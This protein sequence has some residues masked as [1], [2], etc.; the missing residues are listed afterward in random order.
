MPREWPA[1]GETV[2]LLRRLIRFDTR[3]PPGNEQPAA[4]FMVELF[5][6]EGIEARTYEA[7]PGRLQ[8][9]ARLKGSSKKRPVMLLAHTD[10]VGVERE[11]WSC[12][13]FEG[14]VRDGCVYGRG[15]IDDKGM[16]AANAMALLLLNRKIKAGQ[17]ALTR[18]VVF[19]ATADEEAGGEWGMGWL[20][21]IH[22][23][24]LDAEFALNEGGRTR[25]IAGGRRYLAIQSVEKI[26]HVV[27]VTARG[28]AGHSAVPLPNNSI[29]A[30]SRAMARIGAH[31][32]PLF[33]TSITRRFFAGLA[34]I[35]PEPKVAEAMR[36]LASGDEAEAQR[37]ADIIAGIP[38]FNA[39]IRAGISA[40]VMS[41]GQQFNVI[42]ALASAVLNVRTIPGQKIEEV[43]AR[44]REAVNDPSIDVA[45]TSSGAEAPASDPESEM[46][47]ALSNAALALDP[48]ITVVPY[49]SNGVTDSARLRLLGVN[50]YG[51]LP[52]PMPQAD[53]E[54]MH[55]HDER[56]PIESLHFGTRLIFETLVTVAS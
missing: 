22:P 5:T 12:D 15:A 56:I 2:E 45:I 47:T 27:T 25:I 30:L 32:E 1:G 19:V 23:E 37:A 44:I 53:E 4:E 10:V 24:L 20:V 36:T 40:T 8:V 3:N 54:R 6:R 46:F 17:F 18:D 31:V 35:W 34:E 42:P 51:I 28:S 7:A 26:S 55:G 14:V 43:V 33:L 39:G 29:F 21:K 38:V 11:S 41:A 52:F 13:P 16:L 48:E 49:L 9:Y 50:A